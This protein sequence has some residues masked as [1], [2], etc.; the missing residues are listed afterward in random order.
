MLL[1]RA[2]LLAVVRRLTAAEQYGPIEERM[3]ALVADTR[4]DVLRE[5]RRVGLPAHAG[6]CRCS[7]SA[8]TGKRRTPTMSGCAASTST[9]RCRARLDELHLLLRGRRW[10]PVLPADDGRPMARRP[11]RRAYQDLAADAQGAR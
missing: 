3:R 1:L 7:R 4:A 8:S 11:E 5:L 10:A 6:R 2:V 9:A